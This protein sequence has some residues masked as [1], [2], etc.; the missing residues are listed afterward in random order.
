M[1][2]LIRAYGLS[3]SDHTGCG[4]PASSGLML[5]SVVRPKA[6]HESRLPPSA[7]R[8]REAACARP[9]WFG[10]SACAGAERRA[11][12]ARQSEPP[13]LHLSSLLRSARLRPQRH[14]AVT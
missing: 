12:S 13:T 11:P 4:R 7:V 3:V 6:A 2:L 5:T 9:P 10:R 8:D 14:S 1:V